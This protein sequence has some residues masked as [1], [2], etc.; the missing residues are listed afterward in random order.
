MHCETKQVLTKQK[1]KTMHYLGNRQEIFNK[2][3]KKHKAEIADLCAGL[4]NITFTASTNP[5]EGPYHEGWVESRQSILSCF[6]KEI[7]NL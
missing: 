4:L 5:I 7:E 1:L 2:L 6:S 3:M